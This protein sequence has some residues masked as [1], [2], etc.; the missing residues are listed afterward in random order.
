MYLKDRTIEEVACYIDVV[1]SW[2][3]SIYT[4][5]VKVVVVDVVWAISP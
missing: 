2:I 3:R 1:E 4:I 5:I